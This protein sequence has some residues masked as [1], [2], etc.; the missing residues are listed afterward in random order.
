MSSG[1]KI[2]EGG[3]LAVDPVSDTALLVRLGLGQEELELD[4]LEVVL[5]PL[6][7]WASLEVLES[8]DGLRERLAGLVPAEGGGGHGLTTEQVLG[9][10]GSGN[11]LRVFLMQ[12]KVHSTGCGAKGA[13][14][15]LAT[16]EWSPS[17]GGGRSGM[18]YSL[19]LLCTL[20]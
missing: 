12:P 14:S 11:E 1:G 2:Q 17:G 10:R 4:R 9:T 5:V 13:D 15:G 6:V 20:Y 8:S 7:D 16:E 3:L 19:Y 18:K